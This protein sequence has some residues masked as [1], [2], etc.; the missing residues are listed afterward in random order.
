MSRKLRPIMDPLVLRFELMR[1]KQ[2]LEVL[3]QERNLLLAFVKRVQEDLKGPDYQEAKR[4][5]A[6]IK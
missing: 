4:L 5:I 6:E 2:R 3:R 1:I